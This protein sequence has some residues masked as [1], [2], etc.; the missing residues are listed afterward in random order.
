LPGILH[1]RSM[2]R[3]RSPARESALFWQMLRSAGECMVF[4]VENL[5]I[6]E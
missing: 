1:L 5:E 4:R 6:R 3:L 2:H